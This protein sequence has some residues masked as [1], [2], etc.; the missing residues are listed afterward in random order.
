M[1]KRYDVKTIRL[2]GGRL[3]LDYINTVHDRFEDPLDDYLSSFDDL[4]QWSFR[5]KVID[6][7]AMKTLKQT[8]LGRTGKADAFFT[9]AIK[10]RELL[11]EIFLWRARDKKIPERRLDDFNTL[12]SQHLSH[13]KIIQTSTGYREAWNYP[14]GSFHLM[15]APVLKDAYDFLL[16]GKPSRIGECPN[17][18]W[19]FYDSS[20]NGSR[21]WCSMDTCGSNVKALSWYHKHKSKDT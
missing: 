21:R 19:L 8:A 13:I 11:Y 6:P 10:L 15:M 17:C 9:D 18:G 16:H 20:K 12:L 5:A 3:C 1:V 2:Y 4:L 14:P 7:A